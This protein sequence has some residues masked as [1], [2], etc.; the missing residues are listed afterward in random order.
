[1]SAWS[2]TKIVLPEGRIVSYL[3]RVFFSLGFVAL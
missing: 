3:S 2:E 1:M